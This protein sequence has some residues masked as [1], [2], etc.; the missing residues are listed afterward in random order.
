M[1]TLHAIIDTIRVVLPSSSASSENIL[2]GPIITAIATL[3]GVGM[4]AFVSYRIARAQFRATVISTSRQQW[5]E[6]LR[7]SVSE[8]D[9]AVT[10]II[11]QN[12][13]FDFH[14]P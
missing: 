1:D 9:A 10:I 3:F 4:G 14:P 2:A 11:I 8:L 12:E 7:T 5:I 6:T 13:Q